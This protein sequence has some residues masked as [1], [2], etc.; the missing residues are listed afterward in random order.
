M[1]VSCIRGSVIIQEDF[2]DKRVIYHSPL[3][4][5]NQ[6]PK[7]TELRLFFK[8][9]INIPLFCVRETFFVQGL[10]VVHAHFLLNS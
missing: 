10:R 3:G 1:N 9:K 6:Q 8:K 7:K 2:Y 5:G 4:P